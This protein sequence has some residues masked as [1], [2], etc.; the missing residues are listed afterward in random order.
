MF[1]YHKESDT[2]YKLFFATNYHVAIEMYHDNDYGFNKQPNRN[3]KV[4]EVRLGTLSDR[5]DLN[6]TSNPKF[7]YKV[8][9]KDMWP[10]N[11]FLAHNF[12]DDSVSNLYNGRYY[13]E[14]AIMEFDFDI[15]QFNKLPAIDPNLPLSER[16]IKIVENR[17]IRDENRYL[18][19]KL[20]TA[21]VSLDTSIAR[22]AS[23]SYPMQTNSLPYATMDYG[24]VNWYVNNVLT[25]DEDGNF[26]PPNT[27]NKINKVSEDITSYFG[28]VKLQQWP[29]WDYFAGYPFIVANAKNRLLYNVDKSLLNSTDQVIPK[30]SQNFWRTLVDYNGQPI[31]SHGVQFNE[32]EK[33]KFYGLAYENLAPYDIVGGASG[34]LVVNESNLPIGLLFGK[35]RTQNVLNND[36]KWITTYRSLNVAFSLNAPFWSNNINAYVQPYNLIDG[37]NKKKFPHQINSYK[38]TLDKIYGNNYQTA[39]FKDNHE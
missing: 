36:D 35:D 16:K 24:S 18:T 1:D 5:Y 9:D 4:I 31:A 12:M 23:G 15:A 2:K 25:R 7:T 13:T 20:N 22:F 19:K 39:I 38:E 17:R 32:E 27:I 3:K 29:Q 21:I 14:F 6:N 33:S 30:V 37:R 26:I 11:L 8:L 28:D 10:R 34:S